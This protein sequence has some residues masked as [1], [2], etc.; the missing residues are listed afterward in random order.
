MKNM[1]KKN[2]EILLYP[3]ANARRE[4]SLLCQYQLSPLIANIFKLKS[5]LRIIKRQTSSTSHYDPINRHTKHMFKIIQ[6][7][8]NF[9]FGGKTHL[10]RQ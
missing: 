1:T 8:F 4:H 6:I 7:L 5:N 10:V 9:F 2:E 3:A